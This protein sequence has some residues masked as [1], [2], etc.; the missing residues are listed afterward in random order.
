ME[1]NKLY[2]AVQKTITLADGR[3]I[4]IETGKLAKQADGSVV[5]RMGDTMLLGTVVA[6]KDAKEGTDFMPLQVEYKEKYASCGRFPGGFMKREGKAGDSEILVARL[7]DRALR[8]LFP[9]DYHAE[10]FVTVNLISAEKDIQPDALAGLAA[11]A[12]LAVSDIPFGGPISEVRVARIGG[13]YVINPG[14]EAMKEADLDIM[15][16]GTIDNIL[17][18]EGEMNEVSEEVMLGAIMFAHEEIKKHCAVQ[19]ELMKELGK[20]VKREYCHETNDEELRQT[21]ITELYDKAYAIAT[22]G[23]MKHE[24]AEAFDALEAE[25]AS[26]YTEEELEEKAPLIHKYFHDDV[27]KKAMRNMIL[28]EGKRLDGRRTDEIRPIW[29]EIDYL[30]CAHGSAIFTRGETQSLTTVTLGTKLDEKQKD[31]VLVQG[32]EQFVLHYNFPPFSTGEARPARGLS[33]REIGHGH[34]AWRALK[35]MVPLGE[36]N[37]YAVRVVSDILESNGSSSMATVCAGTLALMDAGVKLRKP[38]SGI[39]MGLIS[40][41]A[42]GRWAVLSDILGD[43]DHLGDMD[44][45]VTGTRDGITATQMDIKV[46]GLSYEVLAKALEQARQGR[47]HIL[48][49]LVE[50]IAEPREDYKPFVPRIVQISIPQDFIG[51]VIGPGGKVIQEIQKTTGTTITITEVDEKGIVDIFGQDKESLD[52]ALARIKGIVAV[53]E[54]G[55]TYNGKIRSIVDFGAFVEILPGKD[56]LLHISEIDY[57]R[58]ETMEETGLKEGDMIEVKLIA[59]DAKTGKLK[60]SRK[61]LLPKPEGWVEREPRERK[62]REQHDGEKREQRGPR[63]ER[64]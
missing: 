38:V 3:E 5:V 39:A 25:F 64:R 4:M 41:S 23:T 34:L 43:E 54:I 22:S 32:S 31:E 14:F 51:A 1:V 19:I 35:P 45:K 49:K 59:K 11:S 47:L 50:T 18:V 13:E 36:E 2:N 24:R 60:L 46:D 33:R 44:F 61:A 37:P 6:A 57:K 28:D 15:V 63:R 12:A 20:D 21:I 48:D 30:P 58:F 42:T 29:C 8:P 56:A 40:D 53:P 62:P 17:M 27:Q 16:G 7:I 26:R 9:A 55:E 52:A 10:V